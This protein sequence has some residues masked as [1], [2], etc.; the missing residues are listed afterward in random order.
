M[1]ATTPLWS[2][3]HTNSLYCAIRYISKIWSLRGVTEI[4]SFYC[5]C[6]FLKLRLCRVS[7]IY[8]QPPSRALNLIYTQPIF[9]LR[10]EIYHKCRCKRRHCRE[11]RFLP[12]CWLANLISQGEHRLYYVTAIEQMSFT[13]IGTFV[14]AV[15]RPV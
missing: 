12:V 5:I 8:G 13:G 6:I 4:R 2:I 11:H 15:G 9:K 1:W 3:C 7:E 14:Q 10:K